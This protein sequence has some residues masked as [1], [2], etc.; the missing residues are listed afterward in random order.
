MTLDPPLLRALMQMWMMGGAEG[1]ARAIRGLVQA[2]QELILCSSLKAW[3]GPEDLQRPRLLV[4][5][6]PIF[7]CLICGTPATAWLDKLCVS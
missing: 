4:I 7:L 6:V 1:G 2:V 5:S 3:L